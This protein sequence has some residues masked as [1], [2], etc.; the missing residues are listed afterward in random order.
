MIY[1]LKLLV[2][3]PIALVW[4]LFFACVTG[5]F[6]VCTYIDQVVGDYLDRTMSN[7]SIFRRK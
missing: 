1:Y 5:L 6:R 2:L 3:V 4:D 7:A